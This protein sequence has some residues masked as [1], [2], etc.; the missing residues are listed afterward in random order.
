LWVITALLLIVALFNGFGQ[1]VFSY[2]FYGKTAEIAKPKY[3]QGVYEQWYQGEKN[4]AKIEG[5]EWQDPRKTEQASL[6]GSWKWWISFGIL[7]LIAISYS[8][9]IILDKTG[10]LA[11][12]GTIYTGNK[13]KD[14]WL[15]IEQKIKEAW[16]A[17]NRERHF[18]RVFK[19][20]EKNFEASSQIKNS[21]VGQ[22]FTPLKM[23]CV[24]VISGLVLI[25]LL[26]F[27]AK[28][29]GIYKGR[30]AK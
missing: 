17:V 26:K 22:G 27:F 24:S 16:G 20:L 12:D 29:H 3:N 5:R 30:W 21:N 8:S 13:L 6:I 2:I 7:F 9:V 1:P 28:C 15:Y 11:K 19:L 25:I 14:L 4:I 18:N 10:H 23:I